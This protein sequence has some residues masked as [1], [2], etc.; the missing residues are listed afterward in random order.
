ME[1]NISQLELHL[2]EGILGLNYENDLHYI[3]TE[4]LYWKWP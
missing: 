1:K 3:L 4:L 2:K